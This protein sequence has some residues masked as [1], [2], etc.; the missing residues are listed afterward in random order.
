[1]GDGGGG[2]HEGEEVCEGGGPVQS[3]L[4]ANGVSVNSLSK[5]LARMAPQSC[6]CIANHLSI[7]SRAKTPFPLF[8]IAGQHQASSSFPISVTISSPPPSVSPSP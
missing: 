2:G 1:M 5:F 6:I 4:R 3:S 8:K 7:L